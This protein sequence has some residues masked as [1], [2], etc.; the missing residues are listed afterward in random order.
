MSFDTMMASATLF[1]DHHGGRGRQPADEGDER[2]QL[3]PADS[4]SASTN[5]SL[6]TLRAR[7]SA[8]PPWRSE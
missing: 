1:D 6:S 7:R 2:E 3:E 5:M 8:G 4:G